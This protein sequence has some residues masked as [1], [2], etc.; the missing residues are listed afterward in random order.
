MKTIS[1]VIPTYNEDGNII[2]GYERV[3]KVFLDLPNYKYEILFIDNCSTDSTKAI[4]RKI[5]K[6]DSRVKCIFNAKN[7]GWTRSS[8]YGIINATGDCT[9]LLAADMQEPPEKIIEFVNEW[10]KGIKIVI[11]IKNKSKENRFKYFLRNC[12]YKF[13]GSIAETEHIKQFMGFGLYDKE[14]IDVLRELDDPI[15]YLRGIVAELGFTRKEIK[16][17]QEKRVEGKTHFSF[18]KTY[19]LAMLGITSSTKVLMRLATLLG[20]GIALVSFVV[21][22][23]TLILKLFNVIDYPT[24]IAAISVGV[25]F[26]G[27]V[28][29]FFIGLLGEY[30]MNIN[31]RVIHRPLVIV[32]ERLNFDEKQ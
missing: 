29:L 30:V 15:P 14:F 25:F 32:E 8:Y 22:I 24:G 19:D 4:L 18:F 17:T 2:K 9:V 20:F 6:E 1:V 26:F 31:T 28:Q 5:S 13:I 10:E 21:A 16:Y 3:K 27:A 7:F 23:I 11:G 12:Y